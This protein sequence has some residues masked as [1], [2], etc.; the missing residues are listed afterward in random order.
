MWSRENSCMKP[1]VNLKGLLA[2]MLHLHFLIICFSSLCNMGRKT[3]SASCGLGTLSG[4]RGEGE[5]SDR[6]SERAGAVVLANSVYFFKRGLLE[7]E[8][9]GCAKGEMVL[10]VNEE[11]VGGCGS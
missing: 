10:R 3:V 6:R 7:M 8:P 2:S 5:V 11:R 4:E 1:K 9:F